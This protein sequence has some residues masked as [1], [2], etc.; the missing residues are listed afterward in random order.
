MY[1]WLADLAL[2]RSRTVL[3]CSG[4]VLLLAALVLLR[5]GMLGSGTTQ[6]IESEVTQQLISREL[7]YPGESSFIVLLRGKDGLTWRDPKYKAAVKEALAGLRRDARVRGVLAPD[8]APQLV[9]ERLVSADGSRVLVVVT[10]RDRYF[11]AAEAYPELRATVHSDLLEAGFTGHLA[12]RKDLD[13]TVEHDVMFAEIVS[14]PLALLVLIAVFRTVTAAAVS[15]GV[16]VLAVTTGVACIHALSYVIDIA[17]YAIN[18]ATLVGLGVA[19][20]Y[21]L[22]IVSRYRDELEGGASFEDALITALD[23]T[24]HAVVF[25]GFAVAIGLGSLLFFHGSFLA[26]MGIGATIVVALAVGFALTFLPALL[27][28]LGPRID[29]GRLP[30]PDLVASNGMW[31][32][33]ATWVMRRPISVLVPTLG[34]VMLLGAPFLRLDFAAADIATLP[35]G[36]EARDVYEELR[37]YFPEQA[38]TRILVAVTYPTAPAYTPERVKAMYEFAQKLTQLPGVVKVEGAVD[39]D[40]HLN[41][42]YFVAD[43]E[44]PDEDL[45]NAARR[46]RAMMTSKNLALLIVRTDAAP[47]SAAARQLVRQI[48]ADRR[49]GDGTATL[50]GPPANDVDFNAFIFERAPYAIGFILVITYLALFWMLRSVLL[51]LKAV[52]MNL[53]SISASFGALVWLFQDGNFSD[54]LRFEPGP[55]DATVPVLLFCAVFGLS[56]DYE[57]LMLSRMRE[58]YLRTG[59]NT[60]AVAEGLERT[61]RLVTSAA[62][63][64]VFVFGAFAV[65]RVIMVKSMGI[66]LAIAVALDATLVRV[67]IV[68]ATM[69]LFGDLNWWAPKALGGSAP[70]ESKSPPES[71]RGRAD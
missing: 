51:P 50:T 59:N 21:S 54:V 57:V 29:A 5:G 30:L 52:I 47:T 25:S 27:V 12:Y 58:E 28:E 48:R 56:M 13:R 6:G 35:R 10:L 67:L 32:R 53:L 46:M 43:A 8:D 22:F 9:G 69:R 63:I 31:H 19:I 37:T 60:W 4:A 44:T 70:A 1:R 42:E 65:A 49:V 23:T 39:T 14:L 16:G 20:D 71:S 26:T 3:V 2:R 66:S 11:Q 7:A 45:P 64:M 38:Q 34:F 33:I 61:G 55:L 17:V 68:P 24:G 40:P 36:V 41:A 62:L 15:V 18:V